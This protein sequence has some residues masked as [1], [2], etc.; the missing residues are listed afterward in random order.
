[1]WFRIFAIQDAA[2]EP[3]ELVEHLRGQGLDVAGHFSG[4]EAG[5]FK[6]DL[7]LAGQPPPIRLERYLASADD[8]RDELNA[9]AAWLETVDENPRAPHLMQHLISSQ[10]VFTFDC[11]RDRFEEAA[12][13]KLCLGL[14]RYLSRQ[15]RGIYQIDQQGFFA[16]DGQLLVKE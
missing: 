1:M 7:V 8:I 14:C 3:A 6:V 13:A 10:Q 5:W 4:D 12:V 9:W 2:P 11:P 15:T 16:P